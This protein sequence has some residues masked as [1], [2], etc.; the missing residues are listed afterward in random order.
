MKMLIKKAFALV[1]TFWGHTV[2]KENSA[3]KKENNAWSALLSVLK[4]QTLSLKF[5][6][7]ID[8]NI[9]VL[10]SYKLIKNICVRV[11]KIILKSKKKLYEHKY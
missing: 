4:K 7:K 6:Y 9:N 2:Y 3:H 1:K 10:K 11:P 8:I 5:K